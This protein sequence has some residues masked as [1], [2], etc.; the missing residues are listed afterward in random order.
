MC[1]KQKLWPGLPEGQI[2]ACLLRVVGIYFCATVKADDLI[3]LQ[4]HL[5]QT[6]RFEFS[7]CLVTGHAIVTLAGIYESDHL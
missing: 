6:P 1:A 2:P 3:P 7:V 5:F 4:D